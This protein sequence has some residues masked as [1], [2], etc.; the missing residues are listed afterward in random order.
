MYS[1]IKLESIMQENN[2]GVGALIVP[3]NHDRGFKNY[4]MAQA[5]KLRK[6][7][8]PPEEDLKSSASKA[9]IP[10]NPFQAKLSIKR[11]IMYDY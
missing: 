8:K 10:V 11:T 9:F 7:V 3:K 1:S 6:I 2:E 5:L 4:T